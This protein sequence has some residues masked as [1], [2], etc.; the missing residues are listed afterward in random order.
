MLEQELHVTVSIKALRCIDEA[1]GFDNYIMNTHE[2]T[3]D[4]KLAIDLKKLMISVL[5]CKEE[6]IGMDQ[7]RDEVFPKPPPSRHIYVPKVYTDRFYFDWK[8]PRKQMIFCWSL[9]E[10]RVHQNFVAIVA[11]AKFNG[12]HSTEDI[13]DSSIVLAVMPCLVSLMSLFGAQGKGCSPEK[14]CGGLLLASLTLFMT[15]S[16]DFPHPSYDLMKNLIP[17]FNLWPLWLAQLP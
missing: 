1:G 11:G 17:Y 8:G 9:I 3:L 13:S 5:K 6:G 2:R 14:L 7:I 12:G 16:C 4:S 10:I 15:K